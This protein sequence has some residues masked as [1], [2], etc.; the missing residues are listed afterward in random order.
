MCCS[1]VEFLYISLLKGYTTT[2]EMVVNYFAEI[3]ALYTFASQGRTDG[4]RGRGLSSPNDEL[5]YDISGY[6]F[7]G[8][9]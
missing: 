1:G 4:W 2:L 3:H 9:W 8:H 5:D 6:R 7:L